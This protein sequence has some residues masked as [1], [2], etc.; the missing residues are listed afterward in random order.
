MGTKKQKSQFACAVAAA[1]IIISRWAAAINIS[2]FLGQ[3]R[4][5]LKKDQSHIYS[6]QNESPH[7][8]SFGSFCD[9]H[10]LLI[11]KDWIWGENGWNAWR[12]LWIPIL[13]HVHHGNFFTSCLLPKTKRVSFS[14]SKY[15][16]STV[17]QHVPT[18]FRSMGGRNCS[19]VSVDVFV[20]IVPNLLTWQYLAVVSTHLYRFWQ[21]PWDVHIFTVP[22]SCMSTA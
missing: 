12:Y 9:D 15:C 11:A 14:W 4:K 17:C 3:Q 8:D 16:T 19:E 20:S 2:F 21:R 18:S 5:Q 13:C 6:R 7:L 22:L 10:F 1:P